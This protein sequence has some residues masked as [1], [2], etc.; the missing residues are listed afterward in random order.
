MISWRL[1]TLPRLRMDR[2]NSAVS[3]GKSMPKNRNPLNRI[4]EMRSARFMRPDTDQPG[5]EPMPAAE[6][7]NVKDSALAH[8]NSMH[9][10]HRKII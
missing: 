10:V 2:A 7:G 1:S 4:V 9:G 8:D 3:F 6:D 5:E